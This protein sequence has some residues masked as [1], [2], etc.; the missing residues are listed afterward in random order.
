MIEDSSVS[1]YYDSRDIIAWARENIGAPIML[2]ITLSNFSE[3]TIVY[4]R[5]YPGCTEDELCQ[6]DF[7]LVEEMN[8]LGIL[9]SL[10]EQLSDEGYVEGKIPMVLFTFDYR[11]AGYP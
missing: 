3:E 11:L 6:K 1:D 5:N 2:R 7:D 9:E 4:V 10:K 8:M